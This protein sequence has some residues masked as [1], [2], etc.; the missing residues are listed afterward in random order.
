LLYFYI[1]IE[2]AQKQA[3]RQSMRV[4]KEGL[5]DQMIAQA[6]ICL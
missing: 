4:K 3:S 5:A 6:K 1:T 2:K